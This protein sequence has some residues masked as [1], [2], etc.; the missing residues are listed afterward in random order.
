MIDLSG[1]SSRYFP[2]IP[3]RYCSSVLRKK[4]VFGS[5]WPRITPERRLADF[6]QIAIKD[7]LRPGRRQEQCRAAP[8]PD[9]RGV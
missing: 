1:C 9:R 8:G 4:V 7:E 6:E 2:D 5:D 3:V